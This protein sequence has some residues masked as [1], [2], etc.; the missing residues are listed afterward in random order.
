M[1]FSYG[2]YNSINHDR[3]YDAV[4]MSMI[5]DGI[6]QDG[7]YAT[8]GECLVVKA[9]EQ[10][11]SVTVSTG[12]AWFNHTWN[13]NDADLPIIGEPSE[14]ILN[15][16]DAVV[17]DIHDNENFRKN[18][19]LWVKG[20]P[21]S[22]PQNP[23]LIDEV[24]HHQYPLAY[25]LREA[26]NDT[27][28]QEDITNTVGTSACPFVTGVLETIDIDD[29]LLQWKDQWA[30]FVITYENAAIEWTA[31]QKADFQKFYTEF[32]LQMKT[33]ETA[34]ENDF[35]EWFQGIKDIF[36]ESAAGQIVLMIQEI[37]EREF[38]HYYGLVNSSTTITKEITGGTLISSTDESVGSTTKIEKVDT[39]TKITTIVTP[40]EGQWEY[41][42][43]TMI[44][45][46]NGGTE[47]VSSYI[48][49]VK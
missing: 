29:L 10:A 8:I 48:R 32:K 20:I 31:E 27:I 9:N 33:F 22:T 19:I 2:F 17:L 45:K 47:I 42:N 40:T 13:Y 23:T 34:S 49:R 12:R 35:N 30:Q 18:D 38:D 44:T 5:F 41:V 21:S 36:G 14:L 7:V 28:L 15:R 26:N 25:I 3:T 37:D 6:I 46:S 43:T 1:A 24:G 4:Q 16:I 11:N 39:G